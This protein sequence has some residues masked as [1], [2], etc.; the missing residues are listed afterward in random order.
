MPVA[1]RG[2]LITAEPGDPVNLLP[3]QVGRG[4]TGG[5]P[6]RASRFSSETRRTHEFGERIAGTADIEESLLAVPLRYGPRVTGVIVISKLG[7]DQ[8]DADDLRL[9]EVMAGHASVALENA[10]LYE[11]QR[12]RGRER[13]GAARVLPR[14]RRGV[15][16]RRRRGARDDRHRR[17][18]R[19][20]E[21]IRLA[22]A[23]RRR[24]ARAPRLV[25]RGR[26]RR[27]DPRRAPRA[28]AQRREPYTVDPADYATIAIDS[29][30][31]RRALRNRPVHGRRTLGRRRS[32]DR[33]ALDARRPRSGAAREHR[34][35][36]APRAPDGGQLRDARAHVPRHRR[37][38]RECA[39]G[40]GRVHVVTRA[41][42]HRPRA[43]G[44]SVEL[45]LE[46]HELKRLELGRPLPRHRE[47][48]H[49]VTD[50]REA[51]GRSPPRSERSSRPIPSSATASSR[52]SSSSARSGSSSAART[53]TTTAPAIPISSR[54][55]RSR[56]SR[57]S[58]SRATPTTR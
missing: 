54:E 2:D 7:L 49:P 32:R 42:D 28:V 13:E 29:R 39:R 41:L 10:R 12:R 46:A 19:E 43:T 14:P 53:S 52:R 35:P 24:S 26:P 50:P 4:I 5:S 25:P 18:P 37:G 16:H 1:F 9:L 36:D 34:P 44:R 30:R 31:H 48:R 55:S 20:P 57:G 27:A 38:A 3:T 11:A 21:H 45:G 33:D 23:R 15:R 58:C 51:R 6:T 40:E 8:F 47:D 56:S 17:D 22:A